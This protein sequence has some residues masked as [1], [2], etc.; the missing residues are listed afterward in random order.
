MAD[1]IRIG[2]AETDAEKNAVYR[3]RY[4]IYVDEMN[5][6]RDTADHDKR[7]F[8]EPEDANGRIFYATQNDKVIGTLRCT[9]SNDAELPQHIIEDYSLHTFLNEVPPT[10]IAI[11]EH[12]LI[13]GEL[14]NT[15]LLFNLYTALLDLCN[16]LRIQLIFTHCPP[17]LL[18][19]YQSLGFRTY[20]KNN[21]HTSKGEF[22]IP[23]V[24]VVEDIDYLQH[25]HSPLAAMLQDFGSE[26]KIPSCIN[27][28]ITQTS[29]V[30]SYELSSPG[31]YWGEVYNSLNKVAGLHIAAFDGFN[32]G[33]IARCLAKSNIMTCQAGDHLIVKGSVSQN[34]FVVLDGTLEVR[35]DDTPIALLTAGDIFGEMAFLLEHARTKDVF[36][37]TDNT[38]VL[39][40]SETML[41]QLIRTDPA[42]AAKLLINI[43]K[44]LCVRILKSSI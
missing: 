11:I 29:A 43:A 40:L 16:K 7:L 44:M 12:I 9:L 2:I 21:I 18:N 32:A 8:F 5:E 37:A 33:E 38:R 42:I 39:S 22:L 13:V 25:I 10:A 30:K 14:R 41:H 17:H 15:D 27:Q 23:L 4:E 31:K 28:N 6:F 24:L 19:L 35:D 3:M 26:K 20:S 36:A 1:E 34:L